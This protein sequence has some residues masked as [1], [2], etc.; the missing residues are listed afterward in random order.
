MDRHSKCYQ[1]PETKLLNEYDFLEDINETEIYILIQGNNTPAG[2]SYNLDNNYWIDTTKGGIIHLTNLEEGNHNILIRSYY[3]EG[4]YDPTPIDLDFITDAIHIDFSILNCPSLTANTNTLSYKFMSAS[5]I[6][7]QSTYLY[8]NDIQYRWIITNT[9][10]DSTSYSL[11]SDKI[12]SSCYEFD[13]QIDSLY[14]D[15]SLIIN[16]DF[17]Q[18]TLTK[19]NVLIIPP[20]SNFGPGGF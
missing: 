8:P 20:F 7:G 12:Q 13:Q 3:P 18:D 6:N 9:D 4:E 19:Q 5:S 11:I 14:Y 2:Y 10:D 15:V 1:E 17:G 16:L